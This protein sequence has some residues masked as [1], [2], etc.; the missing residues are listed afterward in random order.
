MS[1][2]LQVA[3]LFVSLH[4]QQKA[5]NG[6]DDIFTHLKMQKLCYYAQ[7]YSLLY[8]EKPLFN[9]K[10]EA[11]D[12]SPII[13]TLYS[14]IKSISKNADNKD[15]ADLAFLKMPCE[16]LD[17]EQKEMIAYVFVK[18]GK[19]TANELSE[20]THEE[21]PYTDNY[22]KGKNKE[23]PQKQ[24]KAYFAQRLQEH[25]QKVRKELGL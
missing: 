17:K 24:I 22:E 14:E 4:N 7:G 1:E 20:K 2:A 3:R 15:L 23:I 11:W 5:K 6:Q 16:N 10:I 25:A 13:P 21:F 19:Y 9:D 18:Y 12:K 8:L